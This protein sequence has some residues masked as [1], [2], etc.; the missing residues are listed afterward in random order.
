MITVILKVENERV[1]ADGIQ[2]VFPVK[3]SIDGQENTEEIPVAD[4]VEK[5]TGLMLDPGSFRGRELGGDDM[6][7]PAAGGGP[8]ANAEFARWL[9]GLVFGKKLA[10]E[11]RTLQNSSGLGFR[12]VLDIDPPE[13]RKL[14]WEQIGSSPIFP[15]R[16]PKC[17]VVRGGYNP[18]A[19]VPFRDGL[20]P[21]R[22]LVIVGSKKDD[23]TV[24]AEQEVAALEAKL[25][26]RVNEVK[27]KT[28][29]QPTRD[30]RPPLNKTLTE[31]YLEFKPHVLHF[32]G[33]G[34]IAAATGQACLVLYDKG[35]DQ[36]VLWG[37]D[38]IISDLGLHA[39][40]FVF[41]NT[42]HSVD[43]ADRRD[44]REATWSISDTF[45]QAIQARGVLGMHGAV[46]GDSAGVLAAEFY[47]KVISGTDLDVALSLAR[48]E[49][50]RHRKADSN[51]VWDWALPYLRVV[52]P[53]D[54][55]LGMAP[56]V[57]QLDSDASLVE[58]FFNSRLFVDR[59]DER[60]L[61]LDSVQYD[62]QRKTNLLVVK[63]PAQVGKTELICWCLK[64]AATRGR[65]IKYVRLDPEKSVDELGLLRRICEGDLVSLIHKR[66][67][68]KAMSVFYQTLN[69]VLSGA[70]SGNP[71]EVAA[72]PA[73]PMWDD[74]DRNP[75]M[76]P[77]KGRAVDPVGDLFGAFLKALEDVPRA[78]RIEVAASL[79]GKD[80]AAAA[81]VLADQRPFLIVI[82]QVCQSAV[83]RTFQ[84]IMIR[85]LLRPIAAGLPA[86]VLVV[87]V[88]EQSDYEPLGLKKL[89]LA[90]IPV[91]LEP[92]CP[93]VFESLAQE[94]FNKLVALPEYNARKLDPLKW[95]KR[96]TEIG[97]QY[98]DDG[99]NW[100][101]D[102][103]WWL[104]R[105]TYF[106]SNAVVGP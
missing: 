7:N 101:P 72:L 97:K 18:N 66:L 60:R 61:F 102:L 96:I 26:H 64:W 91:D 68:D 11:W 4:V 12:L 31:Q 34:L 55:V 45:I 24:L 106:P 48:I 81:R 43:A 73:K 38:D 74:E 52:V 20:G 17:A 103:L 2:M 71:S 70:D 95:I 76:L 10:A 54:Q 65:L 1:G 50:D 6:A 16:N 30:A 3:L 32:I 100:N 44:G 51:R 29:L 46:K 27:L 53:P 98:K 47:D 42:C 63:G 80:D 79:A 69:A 92:F 40:A 49:V 99:Q 33:H 28:L 86:N 75:R 104:V 25:D 93:E 9:H 35:N 37:L 77:A 5:T 36:D 85:T 78:A 13:L 22:I 84:G 90:A 62:P 21:L 87:L 88:V 57:S 15:A 59:V 39:P 94:Y 67:P 89:G 19:R 56:L 8:G 105:F 83:A 82:D 58:E 23:A 41:L 14:R